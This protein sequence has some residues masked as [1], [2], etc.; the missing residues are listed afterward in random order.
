MKKFGTV[1][2]VFLVLLVFVSVSGCL[3]G[4]GEESPTTSESL[5]DTGSQTTSAGT[6]GTTSGGEGYSTTE[7]PGG[8]T[9]ET[10][11][12]TGTSEYA[13]WAN[14]WDA[15]NPI[16][17]DG[18]QYL[19]TSI[20]YKLRIR[21]E[22][23]G[24]IYEYEIEKSRGPTKIH[25]YGNKID[26]ETGEQ[27]KVDL[28]E[29]EVYEYYGKITPINAEDMNS[30]FEYRLWVTERTSDTDTFFLFP[31]LDFLT[32]YASLYAGTGNTVGVWMEYGDQVFEFYNPAGVGEMSVAPYQEG[33]IN[34]LSNIAD[35]ESIYMSWYGFYNFGFWTA[36]E[37]ENIYQETTG[38]WGVMGYQYNYEVKPDGTMT[39]GG[40]DFKVSQVSWTY[41]LGSITGQGEAVLAANLPV[42]IEAK[43]VFIEQGGAN[44]FTHV[45]IE[46]I[47]FEK[48]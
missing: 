24:P 23:G 36:L 43:G 27:E 13:S 22:E 7:S 18:E 5:T 34:M 25:V 48:V 26:M 33:D 6:G 2:A 12:E 15:Y 47:G 14:P 4:G 3:G 17:I 8:T 20:K 31:S 38:S 41:T 16:Q 37:D 35:I 42:P 40:K 19:I 32:L 9:T 11:T 39:L 21:T 30:T 44:V 29:F 45:K 10:E 28:G 46:D 1:L